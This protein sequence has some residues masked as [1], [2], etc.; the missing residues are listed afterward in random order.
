MGFSITLLGPA[1]NCMASI[2]MKMKPIK[3][4]KMIY[5]Q[6]QPR[7]MSNNWNGDKQSY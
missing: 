2:G 3:K 6:M 7:K 5:Q 1:M 4:K